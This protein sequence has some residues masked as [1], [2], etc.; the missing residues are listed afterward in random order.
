M[1]SIPEKYL[2]DE[3]KEAIKK[4]KLK[5]QAYRKKVHPISR[6]L[7]RYY[8]QKFHTSVWN[9]NGLYQRN[10]YYYFVGPSLGFIDK[11]GN[12]RYDKSEQNKVKT[13]LKKS[14]IKSFPEYDYLED[15]QYEIIIEYCSN[16]EEH[17]AYTFHKAELFQNYA[18]YL[19]KC[20]LLR[21]PF[22]KVILKPIDTSNMK[23]G[24]PKLNKE[25]KIGKKFDI[26]IGAFEVILSFKK[27]GNEIN[28]ELLYSKLEKKNFPIIT[29]ILDKIVKYLPTFNGQIIVYE[30][31]E[32]KI[33]KKIGEINK[34]NEN[35]AKK[36]IIEGLEINVYLLKN[37]QIIN[38]TEKA[39]EEIQNY[40]NPKK[41]LLLIKS[42]RLKD[43][44]K[45]D[46]EIIRS[47]SMTNLSNN[48]SE[49]K[50][51]K[52]FNSFNLITKNTKNDLD[53]KLNINDKPNLDE[54]YDYKSKDYNTTNK[55][56]FDKNKSGNLK[57]K[58]IIRKYTNKDGI[59]NI[60]PL[61]YDSYYIEVKESKQFRNIGF[62]LSFN[63]LNLYKDNFIKKYIGLLIQENAYIQIHVYETK[64]NNEDKANDI[65]LLPNAKVT[66]KK[67]KENNG[68][69]QE[70]TIKIKES[71]RLGIFEHT[72]TPGLYCLEVIKPNYE[73]NKKY[74]ELNK[75]L[76]I[77]NVEMNIERYYNLTIEVYNYENILNPI[78]NADITIYK[79]SSEII[80]ESITNKKGSYDYLVDKGLDFLTI[81]IEKMGYFPAQR[82]FVRK[83]KAKINNKG[84]YEEKLIFYLVKKNYV[85]NNN[86]ILIMTYGNLL[87]N[88]LL[89][90]S[91]QI[92]DKIKNKIDISF[93]DKQKN[94]GFLAT[95]IKY[96]NSEISNNNENGEE[97]QD[98]DYDYDYDNIIAISYKIISENLRIGKDENEY[99]TMNILERF[100]YQTLI[101]TPKNMFYI[102]SPSYS[103]KNYST[104]FIGWIDIKNKLFYQIN[105]LN[106]NQNE[107]ITYLLEWFEFLQI[108]IDENIYSNLFEFFG[109]DKGN[110]E[111]GDRT[112]DSNL[113]EE[114]IKGLKNLKKKGGDIINFICS[115]FKNKNN[116]ISF[117]L[118]K[119]I[120][121]SNL[122]NFMNNELY[123]KKI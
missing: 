97:N 99:Y 56:I 46:K 54:I 12:K 76:N 26:R 13:C 7:Y 70:I 48:Y 103:P 20:I 11:E 108:L 79:N 89:I 62:C 59:I 96:T 107:R 118:F 24:L 32:K 95:S 29:N 121:C 64:E 72:V 10:K 14:Q 37:Q 100:A 22:I 102:L 73:K 47:S 60:G 116:M 81:V 53:N 69:N 36:E 23:I 86:L 122:K 28:K 30:K 4:F 78:Q 25:G 83:S 40:K 68:S 71:N 93:D 113:F 1:F 33:S 106:Q 55:Y 91:T 111:L 92:C 63:D 115:V 114:K 61:P 80:D 19:Q 112:I 57:G 75:G 87:G 8:N 27:K 104:W 49:K 58:L 6:E 119:Q 44:I 98:Y 101:Y 17:Q 43:K 2:G 74:V 109:F 21:F 38:I 50:Y 41:R 90:N 42:Q 15:N 34:E 66:L 35:F 105:T 45:C 123:E 9:P 82:I 117:S 84:E 16:C 3:K 120:V 94:E 110:L 51:L 18:N 39:W 85:S 67:I 52:T 31:E 77:I 5:D 65:I 88:N